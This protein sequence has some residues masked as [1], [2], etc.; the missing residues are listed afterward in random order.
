M[1]ARREPP[2]PARP[3][4]RDAGAPRSLRPAPTPEASPAPPPADAEQEPRSLYLILRRS[5]LSRF[6]PPA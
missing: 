4:R 6:I 3:G 2:R 5:R 1:Q